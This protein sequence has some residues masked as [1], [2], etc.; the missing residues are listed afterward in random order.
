[1]KSL[2]LGISLLFSF[3]VFSSEC[4]FFIDN[5]QLVEQQMKSSLAKKMSEKGYKLVAHESN[6][7]III[8]ELSKN[9]TSSL[10]TNCY[11]ASAIVRYLDV[12]SGE[13]FVS[14]GTSYGVALGANIMASQ[15]GFMLLQASE[16]RAFEEA[17][18]AS[19]NKCK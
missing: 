4:S 10:D 14:T 18:D 19:F 17:L 7:D 5:E 15:S 8:T 9:C 11:K 16:D 3:S 12:S 13:R 1:M 6:A 2:F